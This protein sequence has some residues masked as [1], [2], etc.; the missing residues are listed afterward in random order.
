M[1]NYMLNNTS[2]SKSFRIN[3]KLLSLLQCCFISYLWPNPLNFYSSPSYI[4][5]IVFLLMKGGGCWACNTESTTGFCLSDSTV[6]VTIGT[7]W[8]CSRWMT[9]LTVVVHVAYWSWGVSF[10]LTSHTIPYSLWH[11]TCL[12]SEWIKTHILSENRKTVPQ[13]GAERDS[14]G[15]QAETWACLNERMQHLWF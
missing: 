3:K 6:A 2:L 1:N 15:L 5:F 4:N 7:G 11:K 9:S 14:S 10:T 8:G 13:R 12:L